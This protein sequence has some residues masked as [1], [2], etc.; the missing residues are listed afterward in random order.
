MTLPDVEEHFRR[1]GED[2]DCPERVDVLLDL[3]EVTSLPS[4]S[5]LRSVGEAIARLRA[6]VRFGACALVASSDALYGTAKIF[7]VTAARGFDATAVFRGPAEA[8][9]WLEE[10]AA[11]T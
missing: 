7:E 4:T 8:E 11:Q 3:R 1:L 5:Q 2:P 10:R 6:R 9:A